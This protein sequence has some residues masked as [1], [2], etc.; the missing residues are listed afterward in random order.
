MTTPSA[1]ALMVEGDGD[2]ESIPLLF[3]MAVN[4]K[5]LFELSLC[6]RPIQVGDIT[7]ALKSDKFIRLFGYAIRR[8]DAQGVLIVLDCEDH[9]P[10]EAVNKIYARIYNEVQLA[11]KPVA[12]ALFT[13]EYE[14]MFLANIVHLA[15]VS[16]SISVD[17][18]KMDKAE[19]VRNA[20]G[21]LSKCVVNGAY[22]ER[23]DQS[24]LTSLIEIEEYSKNYDPLAHMVRAIEWM[25]TRNG[26]QYLYGV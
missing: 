18:S 13:R 12:I 3:R 7:C 9:C 25:K 14:S 21:A 1:I 4:H 8:P 20:K 22:R 17:A 19:S 23:R 26:D 16:K 24:R 15:K 5:E 6:S 10:V 2:V 11:K